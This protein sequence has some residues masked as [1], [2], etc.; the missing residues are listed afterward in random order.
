MAVTTATVEPSRLGRNV[1]LLSGS[2]AITWTMS[3]AWTVVVPRALGP[4]NLGLI[5]T[6]LSVTGVV[7]I[8]VGLGTKT[9]L[10]REMVLLPGDAPQLTGTALVLRTLLT[11]V[12]ALAIA[13]YAAVAGI[14]GDARTVLWLIA[15]ATFLTLLAEPFQAA[16]QARERME[17]LAYSDVIGKSAQALAGVALALVGVRAIG[18]AVL[19]AAIAVIVLVADAVWLRRLMTIS[20][21]TSVRRLLHMARASLAYWAFGVFFV[22]YLWID[23]VMLSLMTSPTVV[24]WYG[25]PTRLFQTLMFLPAIVGTAWLPQL[26]TA[27]GE[28]MPSLRRASRQPIALVVSL[29]LP[30]C[31]ATVAGSAAVIGTLYGPAYTHAIPVMVLLGLCIPPM[32]L[33]I[34]LNQVLVA[35]GRQSTWTWAMLAAVV[36]N[37]LINLVLIRA[38]EDAYGNGAIG[39]AASLV[40]TELMIVGIGLVL[41]GRGALDGLRSGRTGRVA[42]ASAVL[43]AVT[44][45][46]RPAGAIPSFAA[47]LAGF[48][49]ACLV[50]RL[51]TPSEIRHAPAT[52]R[53]VLRGGA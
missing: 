48:A 30:V 22:L 3:L 20:L 44:F 16:F 31:A 35:A 21:R 33:N 13:G 2:Q 50:L 43:V 25:V 42:V 24:G 7:G 46:T 53:T 39:A 51:A 15:C 14:H 26:V 32:Y 11:P 10:V 29:S 27:H 18:M 41:V 36:V 6:A 52:L 45:A 37:P 28:G 47:G 23:T 4:A 1:A 8:V 38:T 49:V 9:Y 5:V 34:M 17:Y 19:A 12:Y 40:L